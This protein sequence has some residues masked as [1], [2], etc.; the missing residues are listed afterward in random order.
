VAA[1]AALCSDRKFEIATWRILL[2]TGGSAICLSATD[3]Q[4]RAAVDDADTMLA[5]NGRVDP[6][7]A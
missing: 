7:K 5:T 1:V 6:R 4:Y 3:A 2:K